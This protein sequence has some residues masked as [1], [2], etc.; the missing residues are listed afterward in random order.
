MAADIVLSDC[1]VK[2]SKP[3]NPCIDCCTHGCSWEREF[4]PVQGWNAK[5]TT[6]KNGDHVTMSYHI[7]H[8]PLF[9]RHPARKTDKMELNEA[10]SKFFLERMH[11]EMCRGMKEE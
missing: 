2:C 8:C 10:Q 1:L 3:G 11:N 4:K 6:I 9:K 5:R 7:F